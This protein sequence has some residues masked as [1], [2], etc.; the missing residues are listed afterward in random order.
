VTYR[1]VSWDY[2]IVNGDRLVVFIDGADKSLADLE[3]AL[4][5][6]EGSFALRKSHE[7]GDK[8]ILRIDLDP[9]LVQY[10]SP[11]IIKSR[12][13][14]ADTGLAEAIQRARKLG[15]L[16]VLPVQLDELLFRLRNGL[17]HVPYDGTLEPPV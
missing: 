8:V 7:E 10:F 3:T 11:E 4:G 9:T 17:I 15:I 1:E 13:L 12:D 5:T 14:T 2:K 6:K 16:E